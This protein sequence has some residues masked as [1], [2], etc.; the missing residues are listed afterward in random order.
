MMSA[1][2]WP[3]WSPMQRKWLPCLEF[4]CSDSFLL[5]IQVSQDSNHKGTGNHTVK[6]TISYMVWLAVP[7]PCTVTGDNMLPLLLLCLR[8]STNWQIQWALP[9]AAH[10]IACSLSFVLNIQIQQYHANSMQSNI[11]KSDILAQ[12]SPSCAKL[13]INTL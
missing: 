12:A 9:R 11:C 6:M 8:V 10:S 5:P 3:I 1:W 13:K 4:M 2:K 7:I